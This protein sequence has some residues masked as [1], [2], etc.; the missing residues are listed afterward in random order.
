MMRMLLTE[1]CIEH[2]SLQEGPIHARVYPPTSTQFRDLC[3]VPPE[4]LQDIQD[5]FERSMEAGLRGDEAGL[6]M[7]PTFIDLLPSGY[8]GGASDAQCPWLAEVVGPD[9]GYSHEQKVD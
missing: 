7:L 1:R 5:E 4:R 2:A 6:D 3:T 9:V 8:E